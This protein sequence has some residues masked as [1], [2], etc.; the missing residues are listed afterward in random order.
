MLGR[1][2]T[3]RRMSIIL[4]IEQNQCNFGYF[5]IPMLMKAIHIMLNPQWYKGV[6]E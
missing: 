1:G 2:E 3:Y 5:D 6:K 4:G